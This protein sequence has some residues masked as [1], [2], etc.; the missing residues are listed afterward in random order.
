[1]SGPIDRCIRPA[2]HNENARIR[3]DRVDFCAALGTI[4]VL[5]VTQSNAF[6]KKSYVAPKLVKVGSVAS[7]T[8]MMAVGPYADAMFGLM[9]MD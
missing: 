2:V 5:V 6:M 7:V 8:R 3:L 9:M 1:M 4:Q